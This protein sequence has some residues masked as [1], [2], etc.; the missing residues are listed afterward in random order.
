MKSASYISI[1]DFSFFPLFFLFQSKT[2]TYSNHIWLKQK[3]G[4]S[5]LRYILKLLNLTIILTLTWERKHQTCETLTWLFKF[6]QTF[7]LLLWSL[8]NFLNCW[9]SSNTMFNKDIS[10]LVLML[11][12]RS[13][14]LPF[15]TKSWMKCWC[16]SICFVHCE[17]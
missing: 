13:R 15:Y 2:E 11:M 8:R 5:T 14:I 9:N 4:L 16:S 12:N 1:L 10:Q 7:S 3:H 17:L 6:L